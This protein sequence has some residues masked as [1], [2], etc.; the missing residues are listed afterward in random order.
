MKQNASHNTVLSSRPR[1]PHTGST[2]SPVPFSGIGRGHPQPPLIH[3]PAI[4]SKSPLGQTVSTEL[5]AHPTRACAA[6]CPAACTAA[7]AAATAA[8]LTRSG[9]QLLLLLKG[10]CSCTAGGPCTVSCEQ[11]PGGAHAACRLGKHIRPVHVVAS[12][13]LTSAYLAHMQPTCIQAAAGHARSRPLPPQL[14]AA[15]PLRL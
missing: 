8:D 11:L 2:K 14:L 4:G 3:Q 12:Q 10:C 13:Q 1:H 15:P 5:C 6:A 9:H 7:C